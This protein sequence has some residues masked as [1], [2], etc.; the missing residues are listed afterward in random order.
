MREKGSKAKEKVADFKRIH[1]RHQYHLLKVYACFIFGGS[2]QTSSMSNFDTTRMIVDKYVVISDINHMSHDCS[3]LNFT[4]QHMM[5]FHRNSLKIK[6]QMQPTS[7]NVSMQ[8]LKIK[9][10][11]ETYRGD[12]SS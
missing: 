2:F 10:S 5:T 11:D 9:C 12:M 4:M 3:T 1:S 8:Q 6:F 7:N